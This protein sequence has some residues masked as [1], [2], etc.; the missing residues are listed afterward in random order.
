MS[1]RRKAQTH[2]YRP[3]TPQS[4][5]ARDKRPGLAPR[6][7]PGPASFACSGAFQIK[8]NPL[9]KSG[10]GFSFYLGFKKREKKS[11]FFNVI[12]RVFNPNYFLFL[13]TVH[14]HVQKMFKSLEISK[15]S[16]QELEHVHE[17][18]MNKLD[19]P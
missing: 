10:R 6:L 8:E 5:T 1:P 7:L 18:F 3:G 13:N 12:T 9:P 4:A 14:E 17:Q 16:Q 11:H 15:Y 2:T 19:N